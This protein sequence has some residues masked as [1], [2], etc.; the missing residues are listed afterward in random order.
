MKWWDQ[1]PWSLFFECWVLSQLFRSPLSL[2]LRGSL[3]LLHFL[4]Y[5]GIICISE[6]F[7]ISPGNFDSS[8]CFIQPGI[9][10]YILFYMGFP[11]GSEVKASAH[12]A[13]DLGLIPR[14]GRFPGEGNGN[15]FQYSPGK[16]HGRRSLIGYSPWGRKESDTTER[17]HFQNHCRWW[18][19]PW[20]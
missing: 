1:M 8:L 10:I 17:L 5:G 20:N 18:L 19:Q 11:G 9:F 13:G 15:P 4:P 3:V 2:S 12:K 16:S 14:S 7:D 6:L